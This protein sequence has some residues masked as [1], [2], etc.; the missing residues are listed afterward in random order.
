MTWQWG[1]NSLEGLLLLCFTI[2]EPIFSPTTSRLNPPTRRHPQIPPVQG[3]T[4]LQ[5]CFQL[6]AGPLS[7]GP[8]GGS[9][10]SSCSAEPRAAEPSALTP[11]SHNLH[12]HIS[13]I[14][15]TSPHLSPHSPTPTPIHPWPT[16]IHS[17]FRIHHTLRG[18][19]LRCTAYS[20]AAA[21]LLISQGVA[22]QIQSSGIACLRVTD[23]A[24]NHRPCEF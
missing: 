13:T 19:L 14:L 2:F 11:H 15:N 22:T 8:A 3:V 16:C 21:A 10:G 7:D 1:S 9:C 18:C 12:Q 23:A 5:Y 17:Q 6:F 4:L 24:Q 20:A